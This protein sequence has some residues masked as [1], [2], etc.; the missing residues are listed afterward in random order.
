MVDP[1]ISDWL[2]SQQQS[3]RKH[4]IKVIILGV[5]SLVA[6]IGCIVFFTKISNKSSNSGN[7][8]SGTN[9]FTWDNKPV[10]LTIIPNVA[11]KKVFYGINYGPV[12]ASYPW[13]TNTLGD[14]IEDVKMISQLTNRIRLY[15]MDC[16]VAHYTMEAIIKLKLNMTIVP[17]IWID[18]ND[19]TYQRQYDLLFHLVKKYG[20]DKI[21]GISVGNEVI[22]RQNIP[23]QTLYNRISDVRTKINSM[24][25]NKIMPVFTSDIGSNVDKAFVAA[26]DTVWAN[27]H[28]FFAG[29]NVNI[30]ASWTFDFFDEFVVTP[31]KAAGKDSLI[32]EVG[33]PTASNPINSS[34]PSVL[35]LQTFLDTFICSSNSKGVKYY[36]FETFDI[37]WKTA[38]FDVLEGSWGVFHP[39]RSI[40]YP[41]ILPDCVLK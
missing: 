23:I 26:V 22:F 27:V 10:N 34:V 24:D 12:N 33:W 20:V 19:T 25:F 17:T 6:I 39:N 13:C 31:A 16:N 11:Y 18:D 8:S 5:I 9:Y 37:P 38:K 29:V 4:R 7:N 36:F 2:R 15:G 40:K 41:I 30:S 14:V 21:D 3:A 32:S 1:N 35:N 28:P